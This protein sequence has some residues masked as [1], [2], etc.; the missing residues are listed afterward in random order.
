MK[1]VKL[2]V[3]RFQCIESAEV[4]FGPGLNVL[5]GPNDL[6]KS[7]LAWAIRAALLL[8]H[9]S[10]QHEK[11]VSWYGGGEPWVELTLTDHEDRYWRVSKTFSSGSAGRSTLE[12]SKDG[13][14]FTGN[15][16]GRQVDEK[17]RK[18]LG[19]GIA[20][21]GGQGKP[22]GLPDT[23]LT[24]VLLAEQDNVRNVLF[25]T[26]LTDDPDPSGRL[27]L[28][29]ALGAL[30]QDPLFKGVLDEAQR[31]VD[32]AFTATGKK[33]KSADSPFV[34]LSN[35]INEMIRERD[36]LDAK[37]RETAAAE[38]RIRELIAVRDTTARALAET[39][40]DLA[41]TRKRFELGQ[42]RAALRDQLASHLAMLRIV[43]TLE[44]KI[45]DA[46]RALAE[47]EAEVEP[48]SAMVDDATTALGDLEAR[49]DAAAT[50]L[51]TIAHAD[52]MGRSQREDLEK[53]QAAAQG[54]FGDAE[55][56]HERAVE[57]LAHACEIAERVAACV[58]AVEST[59]KTARGADEAV[60]TASGDLGRAQQALEDARQRVRDASSGDRAQ[61][62]EL[63][64]TE[65]ANRRLTREGE[66]PPL[67]LTLREV[68][69]SKVVL[70]KVT[71][72]E[73]Q[74]DT[75]AAQLVEAG[76]AV[77]LAEQNLAKLDTAR[78][79]TIALD[80]YGQLSRAKAALAAAA[81][82][83]AAAAEARSRA[84]MLRAE[85]VALRA[86]VDSELPSVSAIAE[87]RKLREELRIADA[88]V[89]GGLSVVIRPKRAIGLRVTTD[90]V[91][92]SPTTISALVEVS[93]RRVLALAID[94]LVDVEITAGEETAR[95]IAVA[96][97]TRWES[98]GTTVLRQH[99]VET[100]EDLEVRRA[101]ADANLKKADELRGK[102]DLAER[103]AAPAA[104]DVAAHAAQAME[105]EAELST[106]DLIALGQALK[107]LGAG[108]QAA[109]KQALVASDRDRAK[110]LVTVDS[111]RSQVTRLDA[112][113]EGARRAAEDLRLEMLGRAGNQPESLA[114]AEQRCTTAL[115]EIDRDVTAIDQQLKA[116]IGEG[117]D[118][119]HT[120]RSQ[121]TAAE[122]AGKVATQLSE[123]C[124]AAATKARDA[125]IQ[126]TTRLESVRSQASD[127]DKHGVWRTPLANGSGLSV[128]SWRDVLAQ[129][130][131]HRD[132]VRIHRDQLAEQLRILELEHANA[133]KVARDAHQVSEAS[134]RVGRKKLDTI[135]NA[136]QDLRASISATQVSLAGM[137]AERATANPAA[138]RAA[139]D[140]LRP[141]VEAM[142][143]DDAGVSASH[144][145][146][147][148]ATVDRL[149]REVHELEEDLSRARGALEQVGGAIA[150]ER[151]SELALVIHQAQQR[152]HQIAVEYDAWALL[153]ETL[154][155][156][157]S[158]QGAHLG[159]KAR[160]APQC[161]GALVVAGVPLDE[162][163]GDLQLL[164]AIELRHVQ[165][166]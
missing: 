57:A 44:T 117:T 23:F 154:H 125:A 16:S 1:L 116:L 150:R 132:S 114:A 153:V 75:L 160:G 69:G 97:R 110:Y 81:L 74:R 47:L 158:T 11:F 22:K 136:H 146:H 49:R 134:L 78:A 151:Q 86:L 15:I 39:T 137:Q 159:A 124:Q 109:L 60:I 92:A 123:Q 94:D 43:E 161:V 21:P 71:A 66:R 133:I 98:A 70:A 162:H 115:G 141:Q 87:L 100:V 19:W 65:L 163:G 88:R 9:G 82:A 93:A 90:G 126:A 55:R 107:N 77:T 18:M 46:R 112:Q 103:A 140:G 40:I 105:L 165:H 24:Q 13:R 41:S 45:E 14:T 131:Q 111:H 67:Q 53:Q 4:E 29:E 128:E 127:H 155:Q 84:A 25:D 130:L 10:S 145:D 50:Q 54:A 142:G 113:V 48:S 104:T 33:K 62:R 32:R 144:V 166:G 122:T 108:W 36:D 129:A 31:Y 8:Q 7:S 56:V 96:L 119:Q 61:A 59:A 152:E 27:K 148:Q 28:T 91:V 85:E 34:E 120:A 164:H 63:R 143:A 83:E 99:K 35:R 89:G 2:T 102:A 64:R 68:A 106:S 6:G 149:D 72:A 76:R 138:V 139:I 52:A 51:D 38:T 42:Q 95:A 135:N 79:E 20:A 37:V 5:Y 101:A 30:A 17:L 147:H 58:A 3:K 157:E 80:R 73:T 26:S 12:E 118:E 156:S 121:V